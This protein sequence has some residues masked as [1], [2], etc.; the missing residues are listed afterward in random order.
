MPVRFGDNL[1]ARPKAHFVP[2]QWAQ[3]GPP[4]PCQ[5]GARTGEGWQRRLELRQGTCQHMRVRG[6]VCCCSSFYAN[7]LIC[8]HFVFFFPRKIIG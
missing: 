1:V 4:Q 6:C 7:M 5:V 8:F 2:G 3:P